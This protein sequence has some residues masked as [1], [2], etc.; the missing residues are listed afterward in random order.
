MADVEQELV[1]RADH[2]AHAADHP[3]EGVR[4][5]AELVARPGPDRDVEIAAPEQRD[6]VVERAQGTQG[7]PQEDVGRED[8]D[9]QLEQQQPEQPVVCRRDA[10]AERPG[11]EIGAAAGARGD[12]V[13]VSERRVGVARRAGPGGGPRRSRAAPS[14]VAHEPSLPS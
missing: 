1:A 6:T 8:D 11:H 2:L 9:D 3:V 4:Q 10:P 5:V 12:V 7:A 14:L 13:L